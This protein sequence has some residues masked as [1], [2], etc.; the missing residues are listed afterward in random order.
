M[1][2][3]ASVPTYNPRLLLQNVTLPVAPV[4]IFG[5]ELQYFFYFLS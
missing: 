2:C 1:L 4:F 3:A 5:I